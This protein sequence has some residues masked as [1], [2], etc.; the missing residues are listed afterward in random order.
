MSKELGS[1][2]PRREGRLLSLPSKPYQKAFETDTGVSA[3]R[4]A[5]FPGSWKDDKAGNGVDGLEG[6]FT[7]P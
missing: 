3:E 2:A 4:R 1:T 6:N 7:R 5:D